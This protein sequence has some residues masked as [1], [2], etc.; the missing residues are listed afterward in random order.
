MW[1]MHARHP[2]GSV[3]SRAGRDAGSRWLSF[4]PGQRKPA[5]GLTPGPGSGH[6]NTPRLCRIVPTVVPELGEGRGV[7]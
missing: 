4:P 3:L 1:I 7:D 6:L 5:E 2:V